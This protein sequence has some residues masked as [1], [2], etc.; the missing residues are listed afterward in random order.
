MYGSSILVALC[1]SPIKYKNTTVVSASTT[2]RFVHNLLTVVVLLVA[3][4]PIVSWKV[5]AAAYSEYP[6]HTVSRDVFPGFFLLD[7]AVSP[8]SRSRSLCLV[9]SLQSGEYYF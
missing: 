7:L 2:R 9:V 3:G 1:A 4:Q 6:Q 5:R 8:G